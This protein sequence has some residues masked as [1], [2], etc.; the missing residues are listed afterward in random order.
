MLRRGRFRVQLAINRRGA[1]TDDEGRSFA[2][3]LTGP[4]ET[5]DLF[6]TGED[7]FAVFPAGSYRSNGMSAFYR[8][9]SKPR[10]AVDDGRVLDGF[11]N[12][13]KGKVAIVTGAASGIKSPFIFEL[14]AGQPKAHDNRQRHRESVQW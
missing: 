4:Y 7:E 8:C 2:Y 11:M 6:L 13:L 1:F 9:S 10:A 14:P 12:N 5:A 3:L